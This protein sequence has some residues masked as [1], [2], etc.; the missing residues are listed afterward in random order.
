MREYWIVDP[1]SRTVDLLTLD[2][3]AFHGLDTGPAR[4]QITSPLLNVTV[5]L[6]DVF[7]RLDDVEE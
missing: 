2:R 5:V 7:A 4:D 6:S 3:D 1:A